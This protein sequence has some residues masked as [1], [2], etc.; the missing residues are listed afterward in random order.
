[1]STFVCDIAYARIL[2]VYKDNGCD[3]IT[4]CV[5][6][7]GIES[8]PP[9]RFDIYTGDSEKPPLLGSPLFINTQIAVALFIFAHKCRI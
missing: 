6:Y 1:M 9:R 2:A 7:S 4:L 8:A 5:I 3:E